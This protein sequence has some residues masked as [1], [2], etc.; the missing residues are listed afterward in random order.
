MTLSADIFSSSS[1]ADIALLEEALGRP[2]T[3]CPPAYAAHLSDAQ[4][5]DVAMCVVSR[6]TDDD[7]TYLVWVDHRQ[8]YAAK[9]KR[10]R[11]PS[12]IYDEFVVGRSIRRLLSV[13]VTR[14]YI[15]S[16]VRR[17]WARFAKK[18]KAHAA[19]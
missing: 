3:R 19:I 16:S 6:P 18:G 14:K 7:L 13:G 8:R 11:L 5:L 4:V 12:P 1:P 9:S 15:N 10:G 2:I 17:G